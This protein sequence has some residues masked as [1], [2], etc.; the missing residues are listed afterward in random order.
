MWKDESPPMTATTTYP[1]GRAPGRPASGLAG[2]LSSHFVGDRARS[3]RCARCLPS[4]GW[5]GV[6]RV[7]SSRCARASPFGR[8]IRAV[9]SAP[10]A[11]HPCLL[12]VGVVG[13]VC[14]SGP[15]AAPGVSFRFGLVRAGMGQVQS[16]RTGVSLR[17]GDGGGVGRVQSLRTGVT[18]PLTAELAL[19][20]HVTLPPV[21]DESCCLHHRSESPWPPSAR[22]IYCQADCGVE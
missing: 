1:D 20:D 5:W 12:S 19:C 14:G 3:S 8:V 2:G 16:L 9:R 22:I 4:V 10:V 7:R 17:S 21:H 15:V 18:S 11:A 13:L 6:V